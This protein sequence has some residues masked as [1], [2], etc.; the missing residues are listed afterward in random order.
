MSRI[1]ST[2]RTISSEEYLTRKRSEKR[3]KLLIISA[4]A[5]AAI[6]LLIIFS[7]M[8]F[9]Q[10]GEVSVVGATVTGSS[11]IIDEIQEIFG[12]KYLY[13]FPKSNALIYPDAE[14][15]DELLEKFPRLSSVSFSLEGTEH[16]VV[17]VVEREPFALFC[18]DFV[19]AEASSSCYFL[20]ESGFI[21]DLA[22][23]FSDG[24]YFV[25]ASST[26]PA[27][28]RG[29]EFLPQERFVEL[30]AFVQSLEKL[31]AKPEALRHAGDSFEV[32]L[33]SGGRI[34][35]KTSQDFSALSL[36]LDSFLLDE[37]I[38]S[39]KDF[40]ERVAEIDLTVRNRI[41]W[42]MRE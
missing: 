20:D 36:D 1:V 15:G 18:G 31:G 32:V 29:M 5:A 33:D 39:Q 37:E 17:S 16:L 41:R 38:A 10:I 40:L 3:K 27:D 13:L 9:I 22:P 35:F 6:S 26:L 34:I 11:P 23:S 42:K 2:G 7:R 25:Y 21:F 28:P 19:S 14:I 12:E 30:S 24:V 8:K 4:V